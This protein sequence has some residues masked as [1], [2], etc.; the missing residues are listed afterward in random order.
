LSTGASSEK[1]F[2][3]SRDELLI[4]SDKFFFCQGHLSAQPVES[5]SRSPAYC[6]KCFEV[7]ESEHRKEKDFDVW[8]GEV[9]L[10]HNRR[11]TIHANIPKNNNLI[12]CKSELTNCQV[13]KSLRPCCSLSKYLQRASIALLLPTMAMRRIKKSLVYGKVITWG[14]LF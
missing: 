9:L 2:D 3:F 8:H 11:Y 6:C 14:K 7:I 4:S 1:L 5:M 12:L 13:R 10:H